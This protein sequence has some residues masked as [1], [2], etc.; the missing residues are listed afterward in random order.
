MHGK[1]KTQRLIKLKMCVH[2]NLSPCALGRNCFPFY[3]NEIAK[4]VS[5]ASQTDQI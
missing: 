4:N 1:D 5:V 2:G 3:C